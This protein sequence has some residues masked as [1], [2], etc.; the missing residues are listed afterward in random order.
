[1]RQTFL[2][3]GFAVD[4]VTHRHRCNLSPP[5]LFLVVHP[6]LGKEPCS[7]LSEH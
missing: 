4:V 7:G 6:F 2:S 5:E 1:M 3:T